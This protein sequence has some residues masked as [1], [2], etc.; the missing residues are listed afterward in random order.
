MQYEKQTY[1]IYHSYLLTKEEITKSMKVISNLPI[2]IIRSLFLIL[3]LKIEALSH[4]Y[5]IHPNYHTVGLGFF[6]FFFFFSK[7]PEKNCSKIFT[8]YVGQKRNISR[9]I[10]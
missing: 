7:L 4:T 3:Y 10:S 9:E 2:I 5:H 8:Y 6:F 1:G